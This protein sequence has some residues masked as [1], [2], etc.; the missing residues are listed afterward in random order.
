MLTV[1]SEDNKRTTA[2]LTQEAFE[3]LRTAVVGPVRV[4]QV[5]HRSFLAGQ[6]VFYLQSRGG[7]AARLGAEARGDLEAAVCHRVVPRAQ[8]R[9]VPEAL[10]SAA[11][12]QQPRETQEG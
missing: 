3:V 10:L 4:L 11:L 2:A 8:S 7:V 5:P 6:E 12:L 9:P 1:V